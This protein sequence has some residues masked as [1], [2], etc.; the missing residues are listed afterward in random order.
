MKKA[1]SAGIW[2]A[3]LSII[4]TACGQKINSGAEV[5]GNLG[6]DAVTDVRVVT[7]APHLA[8]LMF[9]AQ[10][11]DHLVGISAYTDYPAAAAKLPIVSDAFIVDQE[12]LMLLRPDMLL[13]WKNG[14]PAHVVDQLREAGYRVEVIQTDGLDDVATAIETIG[15]LTGSPEPARVSAGHYRQKMKALADRYSEAV[16]LEVFYQISS[17]PLY[18]VNG[19][20]YISELIA[21]CGGR[22]IFDDL[23][24]LAPMVDVEAVISRNPE[25]MLAAEDSTQAAFD[26]WDRWPGLAANQYG[27]RFLVPAAEIGR[28][29]PRLVVAGVAVCEALAEA[30][31]NRQAGN[32]RD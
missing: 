12:Q 16:P 9:A 17:R 8:E 19:V 3:A 26:V 21:L 14:T 28:A 30:R 18:T 4:L 11:G 15:Q 32:V 27:N 2:V 13:A 5:A 7:L 22:N 10:A 1:C 31:R 25:V 24:E 23:D 6:T 29:T 20:H